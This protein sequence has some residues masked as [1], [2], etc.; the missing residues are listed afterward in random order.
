MPPRQSRH[1][2]VVSAGWVSSVNSPSMRFGGNWDAMNTWTGPA[3]GNLSPLSEQDSSGSDVLGIYGSTK[4][5]P[6]R[7]SVEF[8]EELTQ[9]SEGGRLLIRP[10]ST[11]IVN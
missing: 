11:G 8:A 2:T 5:A 4:N 6:S 10:C 9:K 7:R 3:S 1:S